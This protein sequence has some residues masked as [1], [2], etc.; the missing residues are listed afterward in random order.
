[1]MATNC[2]EYDI[3]VNNVSVLQYTVHMDRKGT[4]MLTFMASMEV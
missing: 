1:M 3:T 4:G 2:L